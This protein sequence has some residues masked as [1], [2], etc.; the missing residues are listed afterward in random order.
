MTPSSVDDPPFHDSVVADAG[1]LLVLAGVLEGTV[2][3]AGE[4]LALDATTLLLA[5]Y[6]AVRHEG[7]PDRIRSDFAATTRIVSEWFPT[8]PLALEA[9]VGDRL[10]DLDTAVTLRL[11]E[12][13]GV[14]LVTKHADVA[15][16]AVPVLHC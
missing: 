3:Q 9:A 5:D 13:L 16:E 1:G 7:A 10:D 6:L 12:A 2:H 14:P 4:V 11:A 15:S 8:R